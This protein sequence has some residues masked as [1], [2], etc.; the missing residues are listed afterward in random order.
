MLWS[1]LLLSALAR[2]EKA[3]LLIIDVQDC[4]LPG[5]SLA[6]DKADRILSKISE[7]YEE[8]D[9]LFDFV[10]RSQDFHPERHISFGSTHH[11][12]PFSDLPGPV[13]LGKGELP[14]TCVKPSS[15]QTADA[16][17]C[18]SFYLKPSAFNC[19]EQLCPGGEMS[20]FYGRIH[21]LVSL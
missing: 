8:K 18:P 1:F 17:C 16:S 3:A 4:F 12:P 13:G 7:I 9:C 21:S 10:V 20:V 2:G 15:G 11:L 5:G 6:V 19:S 14:V